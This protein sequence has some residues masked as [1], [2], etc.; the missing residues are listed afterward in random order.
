MIKQLSQPRNNCL[1]KEEGPQRRIQTSKRDRCC[2]S[3]LQK[4]KGPWQV[5]SNLDQIVKPVK[6][7]PS[8]KA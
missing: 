4:K 7:F 8:I 1:L 6:A 5:T 2:T 3:V